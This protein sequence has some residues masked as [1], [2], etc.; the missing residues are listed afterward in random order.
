MMIT[1]GA[2]KQVSWGPRRVIDGTAERAEISVYPGAVCT[3]SS[4]NPSFKDHSSE[5]GVAVEQGLK[6][7]GCHPR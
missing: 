5:S 4:A 2:L 1:P 7:T 6:P 3:R